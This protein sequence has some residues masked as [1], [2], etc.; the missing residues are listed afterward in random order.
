MDC[1]YLTAGTVGGRVTFFCHAQP[2]RATESIIFY[3]P[4]KDELKDFCQNSE[5]FASCPRFKAFQNHQ[6]ISLIKS[7]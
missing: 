6:R 4:T 3:K 2:L 7:K 5:E 1:I